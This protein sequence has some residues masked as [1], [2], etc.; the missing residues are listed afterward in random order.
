MT[1]RRKAALVES[2]MSKLLETI[3][4]LPPDEVLNDLARRD[5]DDLDE[6]E[7]KRGEWQPAVD[8]K[9]KIRATP[10]LET[11]IDH[12]EI[13]E[14]ATG[15]LINH[16]VAYHVEFDDEEIGNRWVTKAMI[17]PK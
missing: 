2:I 17:E 7:F 14:G 3:S 6:S 5:H 8:D 13:P 1:P 9:I 15:R 11:D 4:Q 16:L 10:D 12:R